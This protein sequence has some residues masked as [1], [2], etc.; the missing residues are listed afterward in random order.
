MVNSVQNN[1]DHKLKQHKLKLENMVNS[2]NYLMQKLWN[3]S[4]SIAE[5]EL[6]GLI[7][8]ARRLIYNL[9]NRGSPSKRKGSVEC[10]KSE[11]VSILDI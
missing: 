1:I 4:V 9:R 6:T 8:L 5:H 10:L 2:I 7:M 3:V 11:Q